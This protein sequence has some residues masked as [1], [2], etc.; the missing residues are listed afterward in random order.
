[1]PLTE[2]AAH[3]EQLFAGMGVLKGVKGA[4]IGEFLPAVAGHFVD[5]GAFAVNDF[6]VGEYEDEVFVEGIDEAKGEVVV[7]VFAVD[8]FFGDVGQGVVHPAHVPFESKAEAAQI[9]GARDAGPGGRF[10]GDHQ[11]ARELFVDEG[12]ELVHKGDGV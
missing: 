7:V 12:V 8:R 2:F 10:F 11:D 6:V 5:E 1:M 9:N 4:Q 3:K